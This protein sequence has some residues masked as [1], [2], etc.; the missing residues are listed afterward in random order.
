MRTRGQR[1]PLVHLVGRCECPASITHDGF[2][3]TESEYVCV[4]ATCV[5]V[6]IYIHIYIYARIYLLIS[7]CTYIYIYR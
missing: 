6:Y 7:V 5:Y 1:Q 4:Y 2:L 3:V